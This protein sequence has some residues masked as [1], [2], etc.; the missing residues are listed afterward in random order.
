MNDP[1][2]RT[3][4]MMHQAP[5]LKT[6]YRAWVHCHLCVKAL[7][8]TSA[9]GSAAC[10]GWFRTR[11]PDGCTTRKYSNPACSSGVVGGSEDPPVA[12][13]SLSMGAGSRDGPPTAKMM[14]ADACALA[15]RSVQGGAVAI[16]C[17]GR[18]RTEMARAATPR[19]F[20]LA[21]TWRRQLPTTTG[22]QV[23]APNTKMESVLGAPVHVEY[24]RNWLTCRKYLRNWYPPRASLFM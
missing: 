23:P 16:R 14:S 18:M 19:V 20:P 11:M 1:P 10:E 13:P 3:R 15:M 4:T 6:N 24:C 7:R 17:V 12:R 5:L 2:T 8:C 9:F 21:T 22:R